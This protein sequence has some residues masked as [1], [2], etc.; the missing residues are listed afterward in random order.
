[1]SDLYFVCLCKGSDAKRCACQAQ[2]DAI[3]KRLT[4][5][6]AALRKYGR[7]IGFGVDACAS[8]WPISM[9]EHHGECTCGL[10]DLRGTPDG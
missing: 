9:P 2:Y 7:H 10:E 4:Q 8:E 3:L 1:M 6:E 5:V